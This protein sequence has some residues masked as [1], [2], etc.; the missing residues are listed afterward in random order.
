ML[1]PPGLSI[2]PSFLSAQ[3][4]EQLEKSVREAFDHSIEQQERGTRG[5]R[6]P[7]DYGIRFDVRTCGIAKNE[8]PIPVWMDD[9]LKQIHTLTSLPS[10]EK[11]QDSEGPAMGIA[12][13]DFSNSMSIKSEVPRPLT[14]LHH[15]TDKSET[16]L[17]ADFKPN[18]VTIQ[19]YPPG[20]GIP[21]HIDTHS[22]LGTHILSFSL[23]STVNMQFQ[24]A[25]EDTKRKMFQPRRCLADHSQTI[26]NGTMD[27]RPPR[28][29]QIL[30]I[31]LESNSLCIMA[32][33]ARYAWTHG[34]RRRITDLTP[35][36]GVVQRLDRYSITLRQVDFDGKCGC[37]HPDWCDTRNQAYNSSR[38]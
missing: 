27:E 2:I 30:E 22:C 28:A 34:I 4:Y 5:R 33:Q 38:P 36:G 8:E 32:G 35:E 21:P 10:Y 26:N 13:T 1:P 12:N 9:L 31:P 20:S 25:T 16:L 3:Q 11:T 37:A 24:Q 29:K 17:P 23:A 14:V 15:I 6:I 19:H 18:Q 7:L